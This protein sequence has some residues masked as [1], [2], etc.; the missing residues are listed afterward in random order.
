MT[1]R[2]LYLALVAVSPL[3]TGCAA[4]DRTAP[5]TLGSEPAPAGV[6]VLHGEFP[7]IAP[8]EDREMWASLVIGQPVVDNRS[9]HL[10]ML[11]D[12]I[13]DMSTADVRYAEVSDQRVAGGE[14]L[15]AV[16]PH[17]LRTLP[18]GELFL[19][20]SSA[21]PPAATDSHGHRVSRLIGRYV[22]GSDG[23][24]L[25]PIGEVVIDTERGKVRYAVLF[26]EP[27]RGAATEDAFAVPLQ[28]LTWS[29]A[30][31]T[32]NVTPERLASLIGGDFDERTAPHGLRYL[33]TIDRTFPV[34][35]APVG[36]TR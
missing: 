33:G 35:A 19:D 34:D 18:E 11:V 9:R 21:R 28:A 14:I 29:S 10:G 26:Y 31:L 13:V 25:G 36:A 15:V 22:A 2:I 4:G 1:M 24:Q 30:G 3:L 27:R 32:L 17:S 7:T 6:I 16:P 20:T 5:H 23:R 12:F 8:R